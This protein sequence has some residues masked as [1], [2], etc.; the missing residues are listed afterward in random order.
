MN[1]DEV[2]GEVPECN[3]GD[4]VLNLFREGV[5]QASEPPYRHPNRQVVSLDI[6]SVDVLWVGHPGNGVTL[7]TKTYSG[8]VALLSVI[9]DTVD[10]D[11]HRIVH[12]ARKRLIDRLDV[13]L[14]AVTGKLDAIG[15]TARKVFN[16]IAGAFGIAFADEPAWYQ[17]GIRVNRGPE[18]CIACAGIL[19][20]DIGRHVLLLG[21][22][23]RP[24]LINLHPF[25]L[26]V[27]K[28]AVL[29]VGTK[30]TNLEDESHNGL[31]GYAGYADGGADGVAFDQATDDLGALFGSEA[32][33]ASIMH[34]R[35]RIVKTFGDLFCK[36]FQ[37]VGD[38]LALLA[39]RARAA[40]EAAALRS[41]P[42]MLAARRLPPILPP[43]RPIWAM[44]C[45]TTDLVSL[46][47]SDLGCPFGFSPVSLLTAMIPAWNS[48]SGSLRERF[49]IRYQLGMIRRLASS[50]W[51]TKVAHYQIL[52]YVV[53]F[54]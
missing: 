29:V 21:I 52:H 10:L 6:A 49:C 28:H 5:S 31:F 43:L 9:G 30:G 46:G 41:W 2:V 22:A 53:L 48:S 7:A 14:Q 51:K 37:A 4:M 54:L 47:S 11:Q 18:P 36:Y 15:K 33:H 19:R 32:V 23:K 50:L 42:V 24:A 26:E 40:I 20:R 39:Q 13:K 34:Y 27:L 8:A 45:D 38:A 35:L 3:G 12:V 44:S 1:L 16:K 17:L 25:A